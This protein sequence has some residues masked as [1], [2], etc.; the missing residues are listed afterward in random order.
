MKKLYKTVKN[1]F[2]CPLEIPLFLN[3]VLLVA[4]DMIEGSRFWSNLLPSD[5]P[6]CLDSSSNLLPPHLTSYADD[7]GA[8]N[9]SD[10]AQYTTSLKHMYM[11]PQSLVEHFAKNATF[12]ITKLAAFL[13]TRRA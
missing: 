7:E 9:N 12:I 13:L 8:I 2:F 11:L 3:Q 10:F 1:P 4:V 6:F 5:I